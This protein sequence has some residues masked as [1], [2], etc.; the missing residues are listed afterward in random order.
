MKNISN[1]SIPDILLRDVVD[2]GIYMLDPEGRVISWNAG[3]ERIKGGT[4][5][6]THE[7]KG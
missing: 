5:N 7:D 1:V 2:Y 3:A 4:E 6:L